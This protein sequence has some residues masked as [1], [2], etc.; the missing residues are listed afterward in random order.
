VPLYNPRTLPL[1]AG[2]KLGPYE[3]VSLV[4][5]GGMGEVYKARDARLG[6]DVAIKILPASITNE[7]E[8][9]KRFEQEARAVAALNHPNILTIYGIETHD[10]SPY[11]VSELLEGETLQQRLREGALPVRKALDIAVQTAHGIAAAHEKGIVHRD[12]KPANI[13]LARRADGSSVIKLLDFG[14]SKLIRGSSPQITTTSAQMGS[15]L[16]M[17][18]EQLRRTRDVDNRADIWSLG[19]ILQELIVGEAPFMGESLPEIIAMIVSEPPLSMRLRRP[20]VPVQLEA[21]VKRCL[22]KDPDAR[23]ANVAELARALGPFA[24]ERSAIS[25]ERVTRIVAGRQEISL[26]PDGVRGAKVPDSPAV[27]TNSS[28]HTSGVLRS[29][30]RSRRVFLITVAGVVA[31]GAIA[32]VVALTR[33]GQAPKD[34]AGPAASTPAPLPAPTASATPVETAPTATAPGDVTTAAAPTS[35]PVPRPTGRPGVLP[36]RPTATAAVTA[37]TA[38]PTKPGPADF[39]GRK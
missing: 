28:W 14:I 4:G 5:S 7:G 37:P 19:I 27:A 22:E 6:R 26:P 9:L 38:A 33:G 21:V 39:G 32:A 31:A 10:G 36:P 11:L 29:A 18:P 12:L 17:S 8:G 25:I 3:V 1:S 34:L 13:F 20:E 2:T 35:L 15:P 30:R 23:F 24:P 16:Y